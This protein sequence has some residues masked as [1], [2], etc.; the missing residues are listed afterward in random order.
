MISAM[1][2]LNKE[3]NRG[4]ER[5]LNLI[6]PTGGADVLDFACRAEIHAA[7]RISEELHNYF[8]WM[9]LKGYM[10]TDHLWLI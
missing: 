5:Y 6:K 8:G 10:I 2:D 4:R 1:C 3:L 9:I 7:R